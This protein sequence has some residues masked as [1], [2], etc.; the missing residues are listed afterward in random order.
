MTTTTHEFFKHLIAP[1]LVAVVKSPIALVI[2]RSR[3]EI[4]DDIMVLI[5]NFLQNMYGH[6]DMNTITNRFLSLK[7]RLNLTVFALELRVSKEVTRVT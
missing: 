3:C 2:S 5:W 6:E 1:S 7:S 4:S